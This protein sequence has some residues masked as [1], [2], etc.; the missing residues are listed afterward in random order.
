MKERQSLIVFT[1]RNVRCSIIIR[2]FLFVDY[3]K[4]NQCGELIRSFDG[5][6]LYS[7]KI[8]FYFFKIANKD[9]PNFGFNPILGIRLLN[10]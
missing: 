5:Y 4:N 7:P 8:K 3:V 10:K 2:I 1:T 9:R 6:Y